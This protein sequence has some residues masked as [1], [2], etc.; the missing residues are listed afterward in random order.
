MNEIY[1]IQFGLSYLKPSLIIALIAALCSI[2]SF[3]ADYKIWGRFFFT[4]V[5]IAFIVILI[6]LCG[7]L[8]L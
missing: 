8:L 7:F 6:L 4:I 3:R 5:T 1:N 2:I